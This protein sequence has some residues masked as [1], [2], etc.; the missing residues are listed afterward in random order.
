MLKMNKTRYIHMYIDVT[1]E[2][3]Y[4]HSTSVLYPLGKSLLDFIYQ[5]FT[6]IDG[7]PEFARELHPYFSHWNNED[8][9]KLFV[10]NSDHSN[11][12]SVSK[13]QELQN[14]YRKLLDAFVYGPST[15]NEEATHYFARHPFYSSG[16]LINQTVKNENRWM[17]DYFIVSFEDCLMC[18]LMEMVRRRQIIKVCKNC[19][20]LFVP[21]RSNIEYCTRPFTEDGRSCSDV[22]YVK[23][24]EKTVQ[25]DELL[26][27][28][29]RAYKT[30]YA[31][32]TKPRKNTSNMT[33]EAFENW[34]KEAKKGLE[35]A[36]TGKISPEAYKEWLKK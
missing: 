26:Q 7:S 5:D 8:I 34:H 24:F 12:L 28:Y 17:I 25:K 18:E 22:G 30:H 36:R 6:T 29:T 20:K 23:T 32:M 1:D 27:A 15:Q 16:T 35:L 9:L 3:V 11:E 31:R 2:T 13:I 4:F 21:K 10:N 33:R 19:G 14:T